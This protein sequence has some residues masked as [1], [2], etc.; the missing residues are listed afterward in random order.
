[1]WI[2]NRRIVRTTYIFG[3]WLYIYVDAVCLC[4]FMS[5]QHLTSHSA[6]DFCWISNEYKKKSIPHLH[7]LSLIQYPL[8]G[9]Y[10][11]A[12]RSWAGTIEHLKRQKN[13]NI[14][15]KSRQMGSI[16]IAAWK[17][18]MSVLNE[19]ERN[20][21]MQWQTST[22]NS[23]T[24]TTTHNSTFKLFVIYDSCIIVTDQQ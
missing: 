24:T 18:R 7:S 2:C 20:D 3:G 16:A 12:R 13:R 14:A 9:L 11:A 23:T 8:Q 19:R 15:R 22:Y 10:Q 21:S 4:K 6:V 17:R 5:S 1:M